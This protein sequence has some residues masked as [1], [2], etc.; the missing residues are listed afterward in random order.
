MYAHAHLMQ[1]SPCCVWR[2]PGVAGSVML[3]R[4]AMLHRSC[5]HDFSRTQACL[6]AVFLFPPMGTMHK[7]R[8][9]CHCPVH[10]STEFRSVRRRRYCGR[11]GPGTADKAV[12]A[13][14]LASPP[15]FHDNSVSGVTLRLENSRD[16]Y[17]PQRLWEWKGLG[18][19]LKAAMPWTRS[20]SRVL[21]LANFL[22]QRAYS[23]L[24][25]DNARPR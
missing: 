5:L 22:L 19:C 24:A 21:S 14:L 3:C 10:N 23:R 17:K 6:F 18:S 15:P 9:M 1:S 16:I 7:N 4:R 8:R 25:Q 2:T 13:D 20:R 11:A 12:L